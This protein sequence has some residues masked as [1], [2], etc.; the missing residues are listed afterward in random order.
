MD[1]ESA[2]PQQHPRIVPLPAPDPAEEGELDVMT[3][4]DRLDGAEARIE[5]LERERRKLAAIIRRLEDNPLILALRHLDGGAVLTA[6]GE[7]TARLFALCEQMQARGRV[8][9]AISVAPSDGRNRAL[10][11]AAD[12]RLTEPREEATTGFLFVT[13]DGRLTRQKWSDQEPE[14]GLDDSPSPASSETA[15]AKAQD[16]EAIFI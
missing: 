4:I 3:L 5:T 13:P 1:P 9:I 7:A 10:V 15:A 14:L 11:Y 12:V 6:A 8:T 16:A 2:W